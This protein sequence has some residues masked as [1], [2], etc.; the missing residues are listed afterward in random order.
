M[1]GLLPPMTA[2]VA[3][4]ASAAVSFLCRPLCAW[5]V[6]GACAFTLAVPGTA[7]AEEIRGRADQIAALLRQ[8]GYRAQVGEDSIGDPMVRSAFGGARTTIFF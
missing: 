2:L 6:A 8:L 3:D 1:S 5:I 4:T 7:M